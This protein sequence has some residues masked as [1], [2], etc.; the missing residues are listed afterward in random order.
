MAFIGKRPDYF[1]SPRH[2]A[3]IIIGQAEKWEADGADIAKLPDYFCT[4]PDGSF[5]FSFLNK[6]VRKA[7]KQKTNK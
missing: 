2:A 4:R 5:S 1:T 7:N 6:L 3:V